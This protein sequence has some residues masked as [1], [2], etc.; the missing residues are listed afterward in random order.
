MGE[1]IREIA[2]GVNLQE[3]SFADAKPANDSQKNPAYARNAGLNHIRQ[4]ARFNP[5][6]RTDGVLLL[7]SDTALLPG[8]IRDLEDTY[9]RHENVVAVTTVNIP[10]PTL[11]GNTYAAYLRDTNAKGEERL[12]PKLYA[13]GRVN[14]EGIVGFGS[15]IAIKTC[16]VFIDIQTVNRLDQPFIH[17][18][19][20]SAEDM[21]L[22]AALSSIGNIYH[23][24]NAK[25]LDQARENPF[26]TS[27]QRRNWGSDHA[28]LY[29]DLVEMDMVPSGLRI[30]EPKDD[31]WIE[32]T[33][34]NSERITGLIINPNQ[35]KGISSRTTSAVGREGA[36][37]FGYGV[38]KEQIENGIK[39]L[40]KITH[41]IDSVRDRVSPITRADLPKPAELDSSQVRYSP[42]ALTGLFVGNILGM[43]EIQK[44]E[45]GVI[46]Q[47]IFFG[48]RQA[49]TW[50]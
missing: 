50:K 4:L 16:G 31:R 15:D 21:L 9:R 10:V 41:H 22:S 35:L 1:K 26:Q 7:D 12:L 45:P 5:K 11:D 39:I 23:N 32:W 42:E 18:P 24:P 38:T 14:I 29:G 20:D 47:T 44:I 49:G 17:M 46:P 40:N 43:H 27:V 25:L 36:E 8:S 19:H 6:Y 37:I 34:P 33:V 48:V 30:I 2:R 13:S 28:V 3:I